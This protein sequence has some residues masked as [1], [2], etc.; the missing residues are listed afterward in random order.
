MDLITTL[1]EH[2][3]CLHF[4]M[5]AWTSPNCRAFVAWTMHFGCEGAM[6]MFL[7]DIIEVPESHS[8]ATLAQEFQAMLER[9]H[10]E[11]KV[12]Y[13]HQNIF[14]PPTNY[15]PHQMLAFTGDN[16]TS[17]D[18]QTAELEKKKISSNIGNHV[19][20]FNHTVQLS[21]KALLCPFTMCVSSATTN[22]EAPLLE[23]INDN[24][25]DSDVDDI[26]D[27]EDHWPKMAITS[28]MNLMMVWMNL[29][30]Q[31]RRKKT[32]FLRR[33]CQTHYH[34]GESH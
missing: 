12:S 5:D 3:G 24:G 15:P 23:D 13:S 10:V 27:E 7:L 8:G 21:A 31:V 4:A 2:P 17:N 29:Q 20:C 30:S 11:D 33:C 26:K 25:D 9:F 32:R 1:Q 28:M 18:T 16:A 14:L 19:C 6:I 34:K 22:D